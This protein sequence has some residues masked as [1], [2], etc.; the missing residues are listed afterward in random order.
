MLNNTADGIV[1]IEIVTFV[2]LS[3]LPLDS[4]YM[5]MFVRRFQFAHRAACVLLCYQA[6]LFVYAKDLNYS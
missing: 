5:V 6:S 3:V 2:K 1:I 4:G